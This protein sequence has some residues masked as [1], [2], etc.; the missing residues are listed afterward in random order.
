MGEE[1]KM[2]R[3]TASETG[4]S[5]KSLRTQLIIKESYHIIKIVTEID[6]PYC[7]KQ[8]PNVGL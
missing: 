7:I 5:M 6:I 8:S 4:H 3:R 1:R 2:M